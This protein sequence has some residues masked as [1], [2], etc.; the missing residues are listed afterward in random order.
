MNSFIKNI[1]KKII[2]TTKIYI[3]FILNFT[4]WAYN[5]IFL[6]PFI[7]K[8]LPKIPFTKKPFASKATYLE[9]HKKTIEEECN[10]ISE[11]ERNLG[12]SIDIDWFSELSLFTQTCIKE[13]KLN[14]NHGRLLYAVLSD[15]LTKNKKIE[16]KP[17]FI[18]ETGTARGFSAICMS[19][20]LNSQN[21]KGIITTIDCIP[22]NTKIYWNSINDFEGK[23]TREKLLHKW[24]NETRNI[25]FIQGWS[26]EV[27]KRLHFQRINFAFLDAQHTKKAVLEEFEFVS[28]RQIKGDIIVFDDVT[29]GLFDGVCE[30]V[31][32]IKRNN[33]YSVRYLNFNNSR[34][35]AIATRN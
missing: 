29:P 21:V 8:P 32:E 34:G 26:N 27:L 19:K 28:S 11:I 13:S 4:R 3:R 35:Y 7:A 14:F 9:L 18:L 22:H 5:L 24:R 2:I 25:F 1:L 16:N 12:F 20:A 6:I 33:N 15:Y 10:G 23:I 31:K 17:V 30:A